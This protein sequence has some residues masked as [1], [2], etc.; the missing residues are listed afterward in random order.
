MSVV[1]FPT[2]GEVLQFAFDAFG[3]LPRKH[4]RDESF[5]E[6]RKKSTQ[7]ALTRLAAEVGQLD[8]N[9][10][11]LLI[12]F[13]YLLAGVLPPRAFFAFGDVFFDLFDTYRHVLKTEGTYVPKAETVEHLM[14]T[15][16][17]TRLPVSIAKHL[18][19]YDVTAD[20]LLV[21][22]DSFWY[23]PLHDGQ[24]WRWP[25]ERVMR[26]AYELAGTSIQRFHCPDDSDLELLNKN[27]D[28]AKKW[29]AEQNP[30]SWTSLQKNF[31]DSFKA[32]ETSRAKQGLPVLTEREMSSV[33]TALFLAR[34]ATHI[35]TLVQKQFGD[36]TLRKFCERIRLA[37]APLAQDTKDIRTYVEQLI[38][39]EKIPEQ[40]W[41]AVWFDVV[42]DYWDQL[43]DRQIAIVRA[44]HDGQ[45]NSQEAVAAGREFGHFAGFQFEHF[46][47]F[48]PERTFPDGF[49]ELLMAGLD[50]QKSQD[51]DL[52]KIE[53]HRI[54]LEARGLTTT[55]PWLTPW[56]LGTYHYRR[57]NYEEAYPFIKE[58]FDMAKY[59]AGAHQ[60]LLVNKYIELSAKNDKWKD[61]T[62]GVHWAGYPGIEVRWLRKEEPTRRKL[63]FLYEI[64]KRAR[65][66]D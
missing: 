36:E 34:A 53:A 14:L 54:Q 37:G 56:L 21:P 10:G 24:K 32:L 38:A 11:K 63:E 42:S 6:T 41:P 8:P 16:V 28:S 52:A 45:I 64:M 48:S 35:S 2:Q 51:L 4:E 60:Y 15:A 18:Q 9:L 39:R 7:T 33:R 19:R 26:W 66:G 30:P 29:L 27:L 13:S 3:V 55:L 57:G 22:N 65:Y 31:D 43:A 46:E 17:A 1:G 12:T 58:G 47:F 44:L 25:L 5:D 61:F 40:G 50:L 62:R 59:C 23:L 20:G 49:V